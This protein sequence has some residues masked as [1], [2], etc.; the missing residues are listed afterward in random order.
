V[1]EGDILA[2]KAREAS[3][4]F[5]QLMRG[6]SVTLKIG[7]LVFVISGALMGRSGK[8][9]A[10]L[11]QNTYRVDIGANVNVTLS[12]ESLTTEKPPR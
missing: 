3:G 11:R 12:G 6:E 1:P 4:E 9:L 10:K 8:V 7:S 5:E 2:L